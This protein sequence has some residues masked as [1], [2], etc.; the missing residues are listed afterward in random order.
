VRYLV[1]ATKLKDVDLSYLVCSGPASGGFE[2]VV[3]ALLCN[4]NSN[5]MTLRLNHVEN[6][7]P[8]VMVSRICGI[9]L[10]LPRAGGNVGFQFRKARLY[11]HFCF[12]FLPICLHFSAFAPSILEQSWS[13]GNV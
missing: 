9:V 5:D 10:S 2:G 11:P 4:P 8:E 1:S 6:A 13:E 12:F 3:A 7:F